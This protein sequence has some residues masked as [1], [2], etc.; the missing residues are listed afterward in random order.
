[1]TI[2]RIKIHYGLFV[3]AMFVNVTTLQSPCEA[4]HVIVDVYPLEP[5]D[6]FVLW[7]KDGRS[8]RPLHDPIQ[9]MNPAMKM[10]SP[11][12]GKFCRQGSDIQFACRDI[13]ELVFITLHIMMSLLLPNARSNHCVRELSF[14][15]AS[16]WKKLLSCHH[17]HSIP[18]L[19]DFY[20][21]QIS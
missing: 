7:S 14:R 8:R 3:C 15:G 21:S 20:Y 9:G 1:M 13:H 5:A 4:S 16:G 2:A 17:S 11:H 6:D 10:G 12:H 18:G 19:D